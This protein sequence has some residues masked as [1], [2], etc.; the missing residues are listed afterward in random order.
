MSKTGFCSICRQPKVKVV[1]EVI[2][3]GGSF[4][5]ALE[6]AQ[7]AGFNFSKATFFKHKAHASST[8]LTDAEASRKKLAVPK[9]NRAVLEAI[10]DLGMQKALENPDSITVNQ[11]LRAASILAE[12]E[13]KQDH[14]LIVLAKRLQ[15][16]ST[17]EII[18]GEFTEMPRLE[19]QEA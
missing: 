11:A 14:I 2:A 17:P 12:K 4:P 6:R 8:L 10:R 13:S 3:A 19:M 15:Q 9:T 18:E 5:A 16:D 1:N 7:D